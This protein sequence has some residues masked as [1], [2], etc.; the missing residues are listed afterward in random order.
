MSP[1][2]LASAPTLE[3]LRKAIG[4]FYAGQSK[5]LANDGPDRWKV[6]DTYSGKEAPGVHVRRYRGRY[7]FE[8]AD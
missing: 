3:A 4:A 7:R 2:L 5:T 1:Q 6:V 8:M